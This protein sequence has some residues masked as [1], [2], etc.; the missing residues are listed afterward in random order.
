[1]LT[2]NQC[3]AAKRLRLLSNN[4]LVSNFASAPVHPVF[5]IEQVQ[6]D[7][8][9][10]L[11][12]KKE[13]KYSLIWLH[14]LG[15]SAYGF[16]DIFID[17]SLRFTPDNVKVTLLT[18]PERAVT[19]NGGMVMN[20]WYDILSLRGAAKTMEELYDKYSRKELLESVEIV[21]K[22]IDAEVNKLS[23]K[24][25]NVWVGGFSQGCALS[26]ATMIMYP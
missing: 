17:D 12:P 24:Y 7:R 20:S 11:H 15:D 25:Q 21:S 1:M 23:G 19:L 4:L 16:A 9:I 26:L 18:A 6:K 22:V 2:L 13:H 5:E 8:S 10:I 3:K 14:G